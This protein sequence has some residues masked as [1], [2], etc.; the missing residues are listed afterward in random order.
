MTAAT[1]REYITVNISIGLVHTQICISNTLRMHCLCMSVPY[2]FFYEDFISDLPRMLCSTDAEYS[3]AF[4]L[5]ASMLDFLK[6][7]LS[8][9]SGG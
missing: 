7:K 2:T 9:V 4:I 8:L 5:S 1:I 6:S 3:F